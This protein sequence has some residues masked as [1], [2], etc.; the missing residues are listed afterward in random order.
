MSQISESIGTDEVANLS[1]NQ[2]VIE[3]MVGNGGLLT[4]M[5]MSYGFSMEMNNEGSWVTVHC[6]YSSLCTINEVGDHVTIDFPDF[7]EYVEE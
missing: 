3:A 5:K 1:I 7:S 4:S 2:F 6:N